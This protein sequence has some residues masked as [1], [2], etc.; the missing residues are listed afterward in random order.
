MFI[1]SDQRHHLKNKELGVREQGS[2]AAEEQRGRGAEG[3]GSRG[4]GEQG[5]R[6]EISCSKFFAS[7]PLPLVPTKCPK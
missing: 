3:Q 5:S 1:F 4:A 6:G 2:R 7:V